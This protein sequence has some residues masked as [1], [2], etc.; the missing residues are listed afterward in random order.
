MGSRLFSDRLPWNLLGYAAYR[1]IELIQFAEFTGVYGI[2]ALIMFFNLVTYA[3]IFQVHPRRVQTAGLG[4][5]TAAMALA[6]MF[7]SWRVHQLSTV[8]P[9]GSLQIAM[10]Q[11]DIPQSLKWDPKFLETSFDVYRTQSEAAAS[12]RHDLIVWPE[13]AAT[14]SSSLLTAILPN[15][16][17]TLLTG[18]GCWNSRPA[19]VSPSCSALRPWESR[20]IALAFTIERISFPGAARSRAGTIRSNSCRLANMFL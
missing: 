9:Q 13:A 4:V 6:L 5:L 10:V 17:L 12:A 3:V 19:L 8:T 15:S 16:P 20:T 14:S 2:S 7:G 1:N 11:G 18:N